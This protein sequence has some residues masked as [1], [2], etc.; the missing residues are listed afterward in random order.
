MD[1]DMGGRPRDARSSSSQGSARLDLLAMVK[2]AG[3]STPMEIV[4]LLEKR[5]LVMPISEQRRKA[6]YDFLEGNDGSPALDLDSARRATN[7]LKELLHLVTTTP[8]FQIC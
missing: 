7:K 2:K 1:M 4:I 5:F 8:E 3:A 6:L